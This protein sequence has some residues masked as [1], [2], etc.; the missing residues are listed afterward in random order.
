MSGQAKRWWGLRQGFDGAYQ[1]TLQFLKRC[2][3]HNIIS[4]SDPTL[5]Y[6]YRFE[7]DLPID[8]MLDASKFLRFNYER[9]PAMDEIR[10]TLARLLSVAVKAHYFLNEQATVVHE[11]YLFQIPDLAQLGRMRYGLIY[12]LEEK[13][14][15]GTQLSSIVVSEWDL[16]LGSSSFPKIPAHDK[17]PV[18]LPTDHFRWLGLKNWR[19][20]RQEAQGQ[21]WFENSGQKERAIFFDKIQKH[22]D[23]EHFPYGTLLHYDISLREDMKQVGAI[24]AK[25]VKKW[26]LPNGWDVSAVTDYLDRLEKLNEAERFSIRWWSERNKPLIGKHDS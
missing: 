23:T 15:N 12:P 17:F 13:K 7:K 18:V 11:P 3:E 2:N 25:G 5:F 24:W 26:F 10:Q 4:Q 8:G 20:L 1:D 9:K 22:T 16:F 21:P 19:I 6:A 14:G